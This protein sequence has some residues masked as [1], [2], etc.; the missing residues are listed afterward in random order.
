MNALV[1]LDHRFAQTPDGAVWAKTMFGPSFWKRYLDVFDSLRVVARLEPY[2]SVDDSFTRID[3]DTIKFWP[4]YFYRGPKDMIMKYGKIKA[5]VASAITGDEAIILRVQS[6]ISSCV[7]KSIKKTGQPYA[8][9]VI[10]NPADI[11]EKGSFNHPLRPII[12]SSAVAGLR[13]LCAQA[14]CSLYVSEEAL[15]QQYPPK[16]GTTSVGI[17]DV[18]LYDDSYLQQPYD[19]EHY[20]GRLRFV[21]VGMYENLK[22]AH[23][24]QIRAIAAVVREGYDVELALVGDGKCRSELEALAKQEGVSERILFLGKKSA[25]AQVFAELDKSHI[26]LL[27]SRHEGLPRAM[28]EAMARALPAIGSTSGGMYEL[29]GSEWVAEKGNLDS[30]VQ[31][32]RKVLTQ[33][34]LLPELSAKNLKRSRDFHDAVLDAKRKAYYE[35]ISSCTQEWLEKKPAFAHA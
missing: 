33:R 32:L 2:A 26:F 18:E 5:S 7:Y 8:V 24:L 31:L 27:P 1:A 17:S 9:E 11:F 21:C 15:Q 34:E 3:S 35:A 29:I 14:T 13:E 12:R 19:L 10:G 16:L 28:V 25:G 6:V 22:K 4:T 30:L 20:Q 23:D